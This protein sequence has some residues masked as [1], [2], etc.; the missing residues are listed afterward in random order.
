MGTSRRDVIRMGGAVAA[1]AALS[2]PVRAAE[3][4]PP[5]VA[6]AGVVDPEGK[7]LVGTG[8]KAKKGKDS[9]NGDA[10]IEVTFDTPFAAAV[11][12]TA[13]PYLAP[14]DGM[15]IQITNPRPDKDAA[16]LKAGFT[17]YCASPRTTALKGVACGFTFMVV[18]V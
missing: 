12:V 13:S 10:A 17:V 16:K 7:V 6:M 1:G 14:W 9:P 5:Q 3:A 15:T 4:K 18:T 11:V 2:S 8:F